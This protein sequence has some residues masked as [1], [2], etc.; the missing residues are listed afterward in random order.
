MGS[1]FAFIINWIPAG[2]ALLARHCCG[3][4]SCMAAKPLGKRT[5]Q[6]GPD[7]RVSMRDVAA[8]A[9]VSRSAVSLA[10]QG[11]PSIPPATRERVLAAARRLGYRKNPLVAAL[12]SIRRTR[13]TGTAT[14]TSLAFL[15]CHVPPDSWRQ[16]GPLNRF[17]AAASA[18]ATELGFSLDEF[19]LG[20]PTMRPERLAAL[21][22]ARGIHGLLVAPLPGEQTRLDFDVADFATVGLGM[23]VKEPGIDRV[24]DD[25]F[26]GAQ[27]AFERCL[28]LGYRRIGLA[29]AANISRRLENRW[30]S[31]FLVAQQHLPPHAR[32][33]ALM[34]ETRE[35]IPPQL[36]DWITRHH[37]DAVIFSLR[38]EEMMNRAPAGVGLVSLSVQDASGRVA[39]IKQNEH[40]VGQE[41]IELLVAKLHHW[42]TGATASPRLILVRSTWSDGLSAPGPGKHRRAL[43]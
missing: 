31:G 20:D 34:P 23:S 26:Q 25:H 35:E 24:S 38:H 22:R 16:A 1:F 36:N 33:T 32:I 6:P 9:G 19:S 12:M 17:H 42:S 5:A 18:R 13:A 2:I 29:L 8:Q 28:S 10:L 43:V 27:L 30:W 41:A 4:A 3:K 11:H 40:Q 37:I 14:R 7:G 21:L 15:T 39:G